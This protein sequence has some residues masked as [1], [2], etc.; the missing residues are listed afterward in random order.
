ML[1]FRLGCPPHG[2][3]SEK[4]KS[5]FVNEVWQ[6]GQIEV[7][8]SQ[9]LFITYYWVLV[10]HVGSDWPHMGYG[11]GPAPAGWVLGRACLVLARGE[12]GWWGEG[13]GPVFL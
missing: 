10:L 11:P 2:G 8:K 7:G 3:A 1:T 12:S 9:K 5:N 13:G 6:S 4:T